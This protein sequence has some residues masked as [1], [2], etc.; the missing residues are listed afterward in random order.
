[1]PGQ[2]GSYELAGLSERFRDL[3]TEWSAGQEGR[4]QRTRPGLLLSGTGGDYHYRDENSY[5]RAMEYALD[6]ARNDTLPGAIVRRSVQNVLQQGF[7]C[8]PQ[9][10][11]DALNADLWFDWNAWTTD[12]N[13]FDASGRFTLH[14]LAYLTMTAELVSGDA[15]V[16]PLSSGRVQ[17]LEGYRCR[18][19][20]RNRDRVVLGVELDTSRRAV[21]Y[22]FTPDDIDPLRFSQL[23]TPTRYA[24]RDADGFEQ[25]FH[26]ADPQRYTQTRGMTAL[27]PIFEELGLF[28]D[29]QFA[30]L[31]KEQVSACFT[32][33]RSRDIGFQG[34]RI[35]QLGSETEDTYDDGTTRT[36]QKLSPGLEVRGLPG[37]TLSA[38]SPQVVTADSLE[39]LRTIVQI[40]C[41]TLDVPLISFMMDGRETNFSGWRGAIDQAKIGWR[42]RQQRYIA[43]YYQKLYRWRIRW[44]MAGE[45][46]LRAAYSRLGDTLY[47]ARFNAPRWPYIEPVKDITAA[48]L[49]QQHLVTS[50]RR[51]ALERGDEHDEL[52]I[53]RVTDNA[54]QIKLA[55]QAAQALYKETGARVDAARFVYL[56][57]TA[58]LWTPA[59]PPEQTEDTDLAF[60]RDLVKQFAAD[61]TIGDV[62]FNL[63]SA[64]ELLEQVNVPIY[65]TTGGTVL[66]EPWLPVVAA[67][68]E[69]VSGQA[70]EDTDSDIVGG[71]IVTGSALE[72]YGIGVR[73]GVLTPQPEDE[74]QV[75]EELGLPEMSEATEENWAKSGRRP[76]TLAREEE[77]NAPGSEDSGTAEPAVTPDDSEGKTETSEADSESTDEGAAVGVMPRVGQDV[78]TRLDD[79]TRSVGE[80]GVPRLHQYIGPWALEPQA[81]DRLRDLAAGT[82]LGEHVTRYARLRNGEEP[83]P[84]GQGYLTT[85]DGRIAILPITGVLTKYGSSL[86]DGSST[87]RVRQAL[88]RA[89]NDNRIQQVMLLIDSPGG[90]ALGVPDLADDVYRIDQSIK[91]VVAYIEDMGASGGYWIAAQA[92]RVLS[93]PVA[94]VGSIG[95]LQ[96]VRDISEAE[97]KLG[98]KTYALHFGAYKAVGVPG[99]P[100][101]DSDLAVMQREVD[102]LGALFIESVARGRK[103][104]LEAAAKWADGAI[105]FAPEALRMGLIDAIANFDEAVTVTASLHGPAGTSGDDRRQ[106]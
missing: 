7:G 89:A 22:W 41:A 46:A 52:A 62:L 96:I 19:P 16:L 35:P 86:V 14:D 50:P 23:G 6:M 8:D 76:I 65:R 17:L 27:A 59:E 70:L 24:A 37:E 71:M 32:I 40:I 81:A 85:N 57:T 94:V 102:E 73:A 95:V 13:A 87:L 55:V 5:Y 91:P 101:T 78:D 60:K 9:T 2:S 75:R 68:G 67:E 43:D 84:S 51:Q 105:H 48:G 42:Q 25:V 15:F 12:Q 92:R 30:H 21:A 69:L 80:V 20:S 100:V 11:D 77:T 28:D 103:V 29:A 26:L 98:V 99:P 104:G 58:P 44:R 66:E 83:E 61:G 93:G 18:T 54:L 1:M 106:P 49:A 56:D 88:R 36:R 31:V 79:L 64:R 10:G 45:P 47:A 33:V 74:A 34:G 4:F 53:E 72:S 3:R 82:N 63:T 97:S 39:F 38:F 90:S